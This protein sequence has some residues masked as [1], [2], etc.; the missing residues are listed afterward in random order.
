MELTRFPK[1]G[2]LLSFIVPV[3]HTEATRFVGGELTRMKVLIVPNDA[4]AQI[5]L[6]RKVTLLNGETL[7]DKLNALAQRN[8]LLREAYLTVIKKFCIIDNLGLG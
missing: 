5:Q 7:F 2:I 8:F 4:S 1:T 3:V 6:I